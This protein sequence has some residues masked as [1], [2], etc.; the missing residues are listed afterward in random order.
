MYT[1]GGENIKIKKVLEVSLTYDDTEMQHWEAILFEG[2]TPIQKL[3]LV[4]TLV[5]VVEGMTQKH[6]K[7]KTWKENARHA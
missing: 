4:S 7:E 5:E 3:G 1:K 6:E 2:L